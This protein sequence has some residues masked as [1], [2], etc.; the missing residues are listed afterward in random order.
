MVVRLLGKQ[1]GY[2]CRPA[3]GEKGGGV[4]AEENAAA[5]GSGVPSWKSKTE[6]KNEKTGLPP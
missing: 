2:Y 4:Y 1:R 6:R 3:S 5:A